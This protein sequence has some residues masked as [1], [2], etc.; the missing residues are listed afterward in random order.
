MQWKLIILIDVSFQTQ[1]SYIKE[2]KI[3]DYETVTI[4]HA[5]SNQ[6]KI[7][8]NLLQTFAGI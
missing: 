3:N 6:S 1:L 8:L 5:I 4:I 2:R 7:S